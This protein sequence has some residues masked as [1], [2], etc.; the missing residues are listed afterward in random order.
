MNVEFKRCLD[1]RWLVP[2][3]P[4]QELVNK[5]VKGAEYDIKRAGNAIEDGDYKWATVIAY[6][7]IFHSTKAL[8][9][10]S[11]YREKTHRCLAIALLELYVEKD[12]LERRYFH[13]L[14]EAMNLREDADYGLVYSE[15]SA[16]KL[17]SDAKDFLSKAKEILLIG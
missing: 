13:I 1:K 4:D 9:Y 17:V 3:K 12:K 5:E 16:K 10:K 14:S 2:L 11:G 6:Y 8:V 7:C 15:T